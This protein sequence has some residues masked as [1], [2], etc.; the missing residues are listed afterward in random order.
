[1]KALGLVSS[2][3]PSLGFRVELFLFCVWLEIHAEVVKLFSPIQE[4]CLV[5]FFI[6]L[7]F[8]EVIGPIV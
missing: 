2:L 3:L 6:L 5:L 8:E 7:L 4:L 1:M